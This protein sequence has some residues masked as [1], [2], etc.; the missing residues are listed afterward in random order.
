MY[1]FCE[2]SKQIKHQYFKLLQY[3]YVILINFNLINFN[4]SVVT[5][6]CK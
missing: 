4:N 5:L 2:V 3:N 6:G 1:I